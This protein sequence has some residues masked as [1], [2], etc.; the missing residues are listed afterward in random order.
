MC[1][2]KDS[3]DVGHFCIDQI[4]DRVN[5]L[6]LPEDESC[7]PRQDKDACFSGDLL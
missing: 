5:A 2:D 1:L 6:V 4:Q 3:T 7:L